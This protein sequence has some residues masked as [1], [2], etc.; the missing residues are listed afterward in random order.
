MAIGKALWVKFAKNLYF[1]GMTFRTQIISPESSRNMKFA[2]NVALDMVNI[3]CHYKFEY[4][5]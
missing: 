5:L 4:H 3:M 2:Y 1:I